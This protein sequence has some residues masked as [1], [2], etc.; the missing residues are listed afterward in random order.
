MSLHT[1]GRALL[2]ALLVASVATAQTGT[3]RATVM[4][5]PVT[6]G[7]QLGT[8]TKSVSG[9]LD[10]DP[11][12][13]VMTLRGGSLVFT[14]NAAYYEAYE[15]VAIGVSVNDLCVVEEATFDGRD[16]V[17]IVGPSGLA[18]WWYD[19]VFLDW[20]QLP[21][22][23]SAWD[24]ATHI[25]S[26]DLDGNGLA[27]LCALSAGGTS[28]LVRLQTS[29]GTWG[30]TSSFAP[31]SPGI[32]LEL[33]QADGDPELEIAVDTL[34]GL[35][36]YEPTGGAPLF[37]QR[38]TFLW[39]ALTR[40]ENPSGGRDYL[41]WVTGVPGGSQQALLAID[42]STGLPGP[43]LLLGP[44]GVTSLS[45]GHI[46]N[47]GGTDVIAV[48]NSEANLW[49]F[50]NASWPPAYANPHEELNTDGAATSHATPAVAN[51]DGLA[52]DEIY[53]PLNTASDAK[54]IVYLDPAL[55]VLPGDSGSEPVVDFGGC[56]VACW[57]L[58]PASITGVGLD[59]V[60]SGVVPADIARVDVT[61]W[62]RA[63]PSSSTDH[64][65]VAHGGVANWGLTAN[66]D[67]VGCASGPE[68][69]GHVFRGVPDAHLN[70]PLSQ[71]PQVNDLPLY[72]LEVLVELVPEQAGGPP[73]Y[74]TLIGVFSFDKN[75][76]IAAEGQALR[77]FQLRARAWIG[78]ISPH[79]RRWSRIS[80][81]SSRCHLALRSGSAS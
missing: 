28:V 56:Q 64:V 27:D 48:V 39:N 38:S 51:L 54:S 49:V 4:D 75:H 17:A 33:A 42:C 70:V 3:P 30:A 43:P 73:R 36:M 50:G 19:E 57:V 63:T 21:F 2:G 40:I 18:L 26:A 10:V 66:I 35:Q 24:G 65:A 79:R 23:D 8:I 72:Y 76:V 25:E 29:L 9:Q 62:R 15:R 1:S 32:D 69:D 45:T 47:T 5:W 52:G 60:V 7:W 12:P 61:A 80:P 46:K 37:D 14:P 34:I 22:A 77:G 41:A 78:P 13:D 58:D 68:V 53:F 11:R 55:D 71:V 59:L 74:R 81:S 31:I 20:F 16:Q 44:A 6:S 67:A